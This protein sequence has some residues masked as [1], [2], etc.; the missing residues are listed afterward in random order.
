MLAQGALRRDGR[1]HGVSRTLEDDEERVTL[2]SDFEAARVLE[3]AAQQPVVVIQNLGIPVAE[4][5]QEP[6][7]ALD[8]G[9]QECDGSG[10]QVSRG[11][12]PP[13]VSP[14]WS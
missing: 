13:D 4:V 7:R 9:E 5:L 10:R 11:T 1:G 14:I 12:S 8:V 2:C 3:D 6:R